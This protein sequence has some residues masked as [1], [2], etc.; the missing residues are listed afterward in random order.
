MPDDWLK[1]EFVLNQKKNNEPRDA[2]NKCR[3][4]NPNSRT[5][6]VLHRIIDSRIRSKYE[7]ALDETQLGFRN[8]LDTREVL[9]A[10]NILKKKLGF[11]QGYLWTFYRLREG[12]RRSKPQKNHRHFKEHRSRQQRR[13]NYT[14]QQKKC[15]WKLCLLIFI[16]FGELNPNLV[17]VVFSHP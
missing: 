15:F 14:G 7:A 13:K 5:L 1:S 8:V 9:F 6:K 12:L 4:I 16:D 2:V 10:L 11:T 17:L 3:L